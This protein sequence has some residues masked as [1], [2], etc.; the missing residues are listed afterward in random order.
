MKIL[1]TQAD[2]SICSVTSQADCSQGTQILPHSQIGLKNRQIGLQSK[3]ISMLQSLNNCV[4]DGSRCAL[5]L[6]PPLG[7]AIAR[8]GTEPEGDA[9]DSEGLA[10]DQSVEAAVFLPCS[11]S[12]RVAATAAVVSV[13]SDIESP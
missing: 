6:H 12:P 9:P 1:P 8:P 5:A 4:Q 2:L 3:A 11:A 10:L 7:V 13:R